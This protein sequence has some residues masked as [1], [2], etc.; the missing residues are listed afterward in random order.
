MSIKAYYSYIRVS[1]VK[2]GQTGT[3][4]E[5]Q[6]GAI[7]RFA[8]RHSLKIVKE[9]AEQ[10]TAAKGGR[11][12]FALMLKALRQGKAQGVIIHKIDRSARNLRDWAELG[13]IIDSGIEVQFANENLDLHSRGG[14]LSADIQAVVAADYIRNLR[15]EVI[16]GFYG[17]IKQGLL[18]RP[19]PVGYLNQGQGKAKA[20]DPV[21]G[22]PVQQMFQLYASGQYSIP[23]LTEHM[24]ELGLRNRQGRKLLMPSIAKCLHNPFYMGIIRIQRHSEFYP[25]AHLPLVS[26][27][28][29]DK[30]QAISSRK[31]VKGSGRHDF[32][33]RKI[34][35]C[36]SCHTTLVGE[37]KKGHVYYRCHTKTCPEK[38]IRE[39]IVEDYVMEALRTIRFTDKDTRFFRHKIAVMYETTQTS[40]ETQKKALQLQTE[41]LQARLSKLTD[42]YLDG[43]IEQTIYLDK[44]N[45]YVVEEQGIKEKMAAINQ[46]L[47]HI[48]G[49]VEQFLELVNNAY[50]SYKLAN[51]TEK[52]ELAKITTSNLS[53]RSKTVLVT[54]RFPFQLLV[55]PQKGVGGGPQRRRGR[56]F[57]TI[58]AQ[59]V[60][61]FSQHELPVFSS[62]C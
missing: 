14:R 22:P 43:M 53:V 28:V 47:P 18:P 41:Q 37:Q 58:L 34:L 56:T 24:Y 60:E 51:R 55:D 13:E 7:E 52:Q 5:E 31:A 29:F 32:L 40:A 50:S 9:Y 16:K 38:T 10:E 6:R 15:E 8:A 12:V 45:D 61:Y 33:F 26:K 62:A 3:S 49:Q 48:R 23:A 44:K 4:L 42:A 25:G 17:R 35:R 27:A 1:T 20:I 36:A 39:E 57:D 59:L 30:V 21:M 46:N 11:P 19:A 54:L 2:Q